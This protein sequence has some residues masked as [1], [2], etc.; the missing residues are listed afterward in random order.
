MIGVLVPAHNEAARIAA[1]L[2]SLRKAAAHPGLAGEAV[3]IAVVLDACSDD[4][5]AICAQHPVHAVTLEARC[6]GTARATAAAW[7]LQQGAHWLASTDADSTVPPEWLVA[8]RRCDA[9]VFC[10]VVDVVA[11]GRAE[12]RLRKLF[13]CGERWGDNH[14]RIHGANLGVS[15][16]AYRQSGGFAGLRCSED[17]DLI[18]R[19]SAGGARI[20]WAG[21]PIVRTSMR[22]AGRASGGFADHL[23]AMAKVR[24]AA[25][26][27]PAEPATPAMLAG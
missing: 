12:R 24:F 19:L 15:A 1:C 14:G 6:V 7:L 4:T 8:Q 23:A 10:G 25:A 16:A 13:R 22:L 5:A 11:E 17:V 20:H 9:D 27:V 21:A 18:T 26:P 3:L 2:R